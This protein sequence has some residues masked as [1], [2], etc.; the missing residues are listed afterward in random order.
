[1]RPPRFSKGGFQKRKDSGDPTC[2]TFKR[3][4]ESRRTTSEGTLEVGASLSRCVDRADAR[5]FQGPGWRANG[6]QVGYR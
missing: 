2:T 6:S 3:L 5:C 1:M 4:A